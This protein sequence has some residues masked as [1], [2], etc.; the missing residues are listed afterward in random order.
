MCIHVKRAVIRFFIFSLQRRDLRQHHEPI[1]V[2]FRRLR[3]IL[4][5]RVSGP[6]DANADQRGGPERPGIGFYRLPGGGG[7]DAAAES[8]GRSVLLHALHSR[9]WQSGERV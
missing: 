4:R 1:H 3:D 9:Y 6:A 2:R 8:L 5:A 7:A